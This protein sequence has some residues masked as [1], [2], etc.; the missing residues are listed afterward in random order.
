MTRVPHVV[1]YLYT[2]TRVAH[3]ELMLTSPRLKT[4]IYKDVVPEPNT[5]LVAT[6]IRLLRTRQSSI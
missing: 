5:W 6:L 3:V 1:T 4:K 2:M